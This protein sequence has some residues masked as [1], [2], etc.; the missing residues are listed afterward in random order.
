LRLEEKELKGL[1]GSSLEDCVKKEG[2]KDK[3]E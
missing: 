3:S 2:E 1:N